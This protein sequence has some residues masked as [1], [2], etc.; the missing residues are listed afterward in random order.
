VR[1]IRPIIWFKR[2]AYC[3]RKD[4]IDEMSEDRLTCDRMRCTT[5]RRVRGW[6]RRHRKQDNDVGTVM[7]LPKLSRQKKRSILIF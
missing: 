6:R 2:L 5:G 7:K 4:H 3:C 1:N